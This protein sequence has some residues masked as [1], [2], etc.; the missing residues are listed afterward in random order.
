MYTEIRDR[1]ERRAELGG[2]GCRSGGMCDYGASR[3]EGAERA[4]VTERGREVV[5]VG[6]GGGGDGGGGGGGDREKRAFWG[7][8]RSQCNRRRSITAIQTGRR[9]LTAL[10]PLCANLTVATNSAAFSESLLTAPHAST[11]LPIESY[12]EL[13]LYKRRAMSCGKWIVENRLPIT[14]TCEMINRLLSVFVRAHRFCT[15]L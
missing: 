5:V 2:G 12:F 3:R 9:Y 11:T 1:A 7:N 15:I 10:R 8:F 6:G 4:V 14:T 13:T